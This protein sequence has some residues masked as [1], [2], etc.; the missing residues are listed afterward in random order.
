MQDEKCHLW[1][2]GAL[3]MLGCIVSGQ[4]REGRGWKRGARWWIW[5]FGT[6]WGAFLLFLRTNSSRGVEAG[7]LIEKINR[8]KLEISMNIR[9]WGGGKVI[10]HWSFNDGSSHQRIFI[11]ILIFYNIFSI[12]ARSAV[13]FK[14]SHGVARNAKYAIQK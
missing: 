3:K 14:I 7:V 9:W 8:K 10:Y 4:W 6:I 1:I 5:H 11:E 13:L 12:S 2:Q